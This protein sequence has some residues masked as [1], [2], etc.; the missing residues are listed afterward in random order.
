MYVIPVKLCRLEYPNYAWN[1][2][3]T[4]FRITKTNLNPADL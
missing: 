1:P 3:D 4:V 2:K